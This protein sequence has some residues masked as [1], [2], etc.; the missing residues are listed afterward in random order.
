MYTR[1]ARKKSDPHPWRVSTPRATI[2]NKP[3]I[4]DRDS[5]SMIHGKGIHHS[6]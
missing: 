6:Y 1:D 4:P 5:F 3:R 2:N